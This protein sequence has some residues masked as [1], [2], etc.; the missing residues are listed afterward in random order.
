MR[1]MPFLVASSDSVE[2]RE[3]Q[4]RI[5]DLVHEPGDPVATWDYLSSIQV[6]S[7]V[8]VDPARLLE[9]TG[10][11][12]LDVIN[13]TIQIDCPATGFRRVNQV[14]VSSD[15]SEIPLDVQVGPHLLAS[16]VE[17]RLG[18][19]LNRALPGGTLSAHR[20]G[21]R[22][23]T[24]PRVFRFPLEGVGS[25]FPTEAFDF[26]K[27]GYPA[28]AAWRLNIKSGALD[29]PFSAAVRLMINTGHEK[30]GELLSGKPGLLQSVLFHGVLEHMLL[31]VADDEST[32]VAAG[33][34][35]GTFGAVLEELT[36]LYLGLPLSTAI[37]ALGTDRSRV[38]A[39]LQETTSFLSGEER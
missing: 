23:H 22:V 25:G 10:L 33:Y 14:P 6:F 29:L 39:K 31:A 27:A 26:A 38:L 24:D 37:E 34:D 17:I 20:M 1:A 15:G 12:A 35:E 11:E 16:T 18:L 7:S 5:G 8:T 19:V 21:S 13:A 28:G 4:L 32:T 9:E 36:D 2:F 30:A 3:P